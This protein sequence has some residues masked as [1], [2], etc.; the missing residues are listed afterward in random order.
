MARTSG[1]PGRTRRALFLELRG[2]GRLIDLPGYGFARMSKGEAKQAALYLRSVVEGRMLA[3]G[4]LIMDARRE[5][6]EEEEQLLG[7]WRAKGTPCLVVANKADKLSRQAGNKR[8]Q[9]LQ[10]AVPETAVALCSASTGAGVSQVLAQI[11]VWLRHQP[12]P[13][14]GER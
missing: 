1:A 5:Y 14:S 3:G 13:D 7:I 9:A 10:A 4:I 8:L 11:R 12:A 2:G 6:A